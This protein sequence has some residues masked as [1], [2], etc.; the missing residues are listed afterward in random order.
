MALAAVPSSVD[1]AQAAGGA[2]LVCDVLPGDVVLVP[3]LW[4]HATLNSEL[5]IGFATEVSVDR[6]FVV[7]ALDEAAAAIGGRR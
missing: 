2:P 7:H 5:S 6:A 1:A 3:P 4:G